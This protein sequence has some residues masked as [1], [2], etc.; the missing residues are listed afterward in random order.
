[1]LD[2]LFA[3]LTAG[4][5]RGAAAFDAVTKIARE[6]GFYRE[7]RVADTVD[8]R[9]AVLA[10]VTALLLVRLERD[11]EAG[12]A[13]SAAITERFIA[14]ME[15]EH[16]EFGLGDPALGKTV[17]KLVGSLGR[18]LDLWR[19]ALAGAAD[20]KEAA[21]LSLYGGDVG[22]DALASSAVRLRSIAGIFDKA[23]LEDI[24]EGRIT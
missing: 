15:A 23:S 9:F 20:W 16:R 19:P 2:F 18:R 12:D 1:M 13:L 6:P 22:S 21:K 4:Q 3:R 7:G 17:R 14:V 10:T 5:A 24:A 11:G 8:G